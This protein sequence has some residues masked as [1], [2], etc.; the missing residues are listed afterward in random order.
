[1]ETRKPRKMYIDIDG[2]LVVWDNEH[3]CIE[4]ARGF[5]RLMRFCKIH[6]IQPF[7]L[8]MWSMRPET[9]DGINC[10]LWPKAC[11]TMAV[12]EILP[13]DRA[14][15]KVAVVDLDSDFVWI[16]DGIDEKHLE[17]MEKR[18]VGDRFYWTDGLDPDCLLKF[19]DFT[20]QKMHLPAE[21]PEEWGPAWDSTW[22]RPRV[23]GGGPSVS[24]KIAPSM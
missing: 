10:L 9:L 19:M 23:R 17:F 14:K 16:E 12:P 20:R 1:M 3:N 21:T 15:G 4:L 18:G 13:Y 6:S 2:V 11:P 24:G 7:W 5:G 22:V 8:T